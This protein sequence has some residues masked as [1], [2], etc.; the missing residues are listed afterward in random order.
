MK[1]ELKNVKY[2]AALT[3]KC[4]AFEA[5]LYL[6]DKYVADVSNNGLNVQCKIKAKSD[7]DLQSIKKAETECAAM[8]P[9]RQ[10]EPDFKGF[11]NLAIYTSMLMVGHM[12]KLDIQRA[13]R[14]VDKKMVNSIVWGNLEE[15]FWNVPFEK[16][17]TE[18]LNNAADRELL[19]Y[20]IKTY[21]M[22][23]LADGAKMLNTNLPEDIYKMAGLSP[24]QY[25]PA[26]EQNEKPEEKI[27]VRRSKGHGL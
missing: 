7:Q 21:A 27:K 19:V 18:M 8:T 5:R 15:R 1:M 3:R 16:P 17:V 14:K 4:Y 10:A 24:G 6:D 12:N 13:Q 26:Q 23:D 20:A 22:D 11:Y 25:L 2:N 9:A